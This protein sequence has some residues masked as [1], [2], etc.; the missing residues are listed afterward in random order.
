MN[1]Y[2]PKP[3]DRKFLIK[4]LATWLL[5]KMDYR[6]AY[7]E[8]LQQLKSC[9]EKLHRLS[10]SENAAALVARRDSAENGTGYIKPGMALGGEEGDKK[11]WASSLR[12]GAGAGERMKHNAGVAHGTFEEP[13][14][15]KIPEAVERTERQREGERSTSEAENLP[16]AADDQA[17]RTELPNG[18]IGGAVP[19]GVDDRVDG[20]GEDK[21]VSDGQISPKTPGAT[22]AVQG[23]DNEQPPLLDG[24][25]PPVEDEYEKV[26]KP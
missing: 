14:C 2:V 19:D 4:V 10:V 12:A 17:G 23:N 22:P 18:G 6:K 15:V 20:D 16:L 3:V 5:E 8:R 25:Q 11:G 7:D 24:G 13:A 9:D 1:D 26:A 21:P